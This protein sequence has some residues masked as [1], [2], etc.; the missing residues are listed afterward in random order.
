MVKNK[1]AKMSAIEKNQNHIY[2]DEFIEEMAIGGKIIK[3]YTYDKDAIYY[4]D[5]PYASI[6]E[7]QQQNRFYL[8]EYLEQKELREEWFKKLDESRNITSSEDFI[9]IKNTS[10]FQLDNYCHFEFNQ[11]FKN[12]WLRRK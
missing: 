8:D 2:L 1:W 4:N 7:Y 11:T 9:S 10:D 3:D 12:R 5:V 6:K